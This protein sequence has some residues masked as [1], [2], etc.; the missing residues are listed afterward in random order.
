MQITAIKIADGVLASN[1][2]NNAADMR[3]VTYSDVVTPASSN[4][5][6]PA[7]VNATRLTMGEMMNDLGTI[8]MHPK[9]YTDALNQENITFV[10]PSKLPFKIAMFSGCQVI[11][12]EDATVVSGANSP[13]YRS[14]MFGAGSLQKEMHFPEVPV[15][16]FRDPNKG[17]GGGVE[18]LYNR[19]H[20]LIHPLGFRFRPTW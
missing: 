12:S 17:N 1:V 13:K 14:Y 8:I 6:S 11:V 4:K 18:T 20:V 10:Q 15:E 5:I 19:R 3:Y 16:T 9:V 2:T 7:A